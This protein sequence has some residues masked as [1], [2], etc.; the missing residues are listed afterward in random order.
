MLGVFFFFPNPES[1]TPASKR[2]RRAHGTAVEPRDQ[3]FAQFFTLHEL[4]PE[5]T[6]VC[7]CHLALQVEDAITQQ[8]LQRGRLV[9]CQ[10]HLHNGL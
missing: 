5:L 1:R 8:P 2:R 6:I 3:S 4:V 7:A 10:I 9:R